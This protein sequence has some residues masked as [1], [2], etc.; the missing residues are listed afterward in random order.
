MNGIGGNRFGDC[1]SRRTHAA[2]REKF[3][4]LFQRPAHTLLRCILAHAQGQPDLAQIP[5]FIK[6]E[7]N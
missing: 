4:Q 7:Q 1:C 2:F 3:P 6:P 5:A